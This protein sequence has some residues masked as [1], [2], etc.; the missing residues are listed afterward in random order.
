MGYRASRILA[1]AGMIEE[2]S[3][4]VSYIFRRS[5]HK[6]Q[7]HG[8]EGNDYSHSFSPTRRNQR[9]LEMSAGSNH[10]KG[11]GASPDL[12]R[13]ASCRMLEDT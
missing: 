11:P 4:R 10:A 5:M 3:A 6:S 13:C 1:R 7:S 2:C 12:A 8:H 9:W